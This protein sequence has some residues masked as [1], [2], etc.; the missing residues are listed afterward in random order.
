MLIPIIITLLLSQF[1]P[2]TFPCVYHADKVA[3]E[4]KL[5][6]KTFTIPIDWRDPYFDEWQWKA[7]KIEDQWNYNR[8]VERVMPVNGETIPGRFDSEGVF[9]PVARCG[10]DAVRDLRAWTGA[11]PG[12]LAPSHLWHSPAE[13]EKN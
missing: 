6:N 7:F 3:A 9:R 4:C 2:G 10:V 5:N 8:G 11:H 1:P 13:C 12:E